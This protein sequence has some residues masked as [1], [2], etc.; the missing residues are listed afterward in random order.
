MVH[1]KFQ[2]HGMYCFEKDFFRFWPYVYG[3]AGHLDHVTKTI[4]YK[5]MCPLPKEAQHRI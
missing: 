3:F 1:A 5:F 4:F 2:D